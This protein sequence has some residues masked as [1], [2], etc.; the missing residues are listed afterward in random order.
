[1]FPTS[2]YLMQ[3]ASEAATAPAA[4]V[5]NG[6]TPLAWAF[7]LSAWAIITGSMIYCFGK[8]LTSKDQSLGG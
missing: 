1:M 3:A 6:M 2:L 8:L 5:A 4:P 7:M